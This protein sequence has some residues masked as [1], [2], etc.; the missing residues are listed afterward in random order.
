[1]KKEHV[2][3]VDQRGANVQVF[4][5]VRILAYKLRIYAANTYTR[6]L[7][8]FKPNA[9]KDVGWN[10][11]NVDIAIT[12]IRVSQLAW[13]GW[14]FHDEGPIFDVEWSEELAGLECP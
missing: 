12:P 7:F 4:W 13:I 14:E 10:V 1:M 11:T 8:F 3:W 2:R 6:L 5:S 9:S